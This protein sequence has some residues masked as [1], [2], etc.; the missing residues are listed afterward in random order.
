M[1]F[2]GTV[3]IQPALWRG[4]RD[5]TGTGPRSTLLCAVAQGTQIH[6]DLGCTCS[7]ATAVTAACV[8]TAEIAFSS[9]AGSTNSRELSVGCRTS[10]RCSADTWEMAYAEVFATASPLPAVSKPGSFRLAQRCL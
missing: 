10:L 7:V 4:G 1:D 2:S 5:A 9:L 8:D 3:V 6:S